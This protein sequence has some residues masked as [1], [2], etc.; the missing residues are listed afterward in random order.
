MAIVPEP[1]ASADL[2]AHDRGM[3][4]RIAVLEEIAS[5]TCAVLKEIRDDIRD[6]RTGL[7]DIRGDIRS[8]RD[9]QD[10]DLRLVSAPR[11]P[12]RSASPASWPRAFTG[13]SAAPTHPWPSPAHPCHSPP[14]A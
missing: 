12:L 1:L 3:E 4:A 2:N 13:S 9:C 6:I 14:K 5:S 10:A 7:R 11:S 8:V